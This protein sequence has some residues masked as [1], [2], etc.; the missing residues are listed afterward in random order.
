MKNKNLKWGKPKWAVER[1]RVI[2]KPRKEGK[3]LEEFNKKAAIFRAEVAEACLKI[4]PS[5][6]CKLT[7]EYVKDKLK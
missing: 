3:E 5:A 4:D 2:Q 1:D 6:S 7:C